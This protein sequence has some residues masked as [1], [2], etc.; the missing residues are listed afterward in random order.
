VHLT[1]TSIWCDARRRRDVCFV[2]SSDRIGA[3]GH[4]QLIG[5]PITLA[6]VAPRAQNG[7]A[8]HLAVP[9]RRPFTL[10]TLRLELIPSGRTLG[11][12]A[13]HVDARGRTVLYAGPVR[14]T[15]S[16]EAA[17]VRTSDAVVVA[18]PFG[19]QHHA[20]APLDD[21]A[22]ELV[23]WVRAQ[24]A[25]GKPPVIVVDSP[26]DGLEVATRL[27]EEG[28]A[29][30]G[31][32]TIRDAAKRL[33]KLEPVPAIRAPGKEPSVIIRVEGDRLALP[34]KA[35]SALVSGRAID[36]Q[37]AFAARFAW[38]FAAGRAQLLA[39]IE[40]TKAK[41]IFVTGECAEAIVQ[42]LGKKARVLGPPHQMTLFPREAAR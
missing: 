26:L 35:V 10:G 41:D 32:A 5:T 12:S 11:A 42:T 1:G 24:L 37:P 21:V 3:L 19:E 28:L 7:L 34:A 31:S 27:V 30:T 38:P 2:S 6:L 39:W 36:P 14:T 23:A 18:A 15:D 13:L 9:V 40:Q 22:G 25:A 20:F 8:G 17:E 29:V 4:G 33:A 16:R